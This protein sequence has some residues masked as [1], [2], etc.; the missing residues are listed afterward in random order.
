MFEFA[1]LLADVPKVFFFVDQTGAKLDGL[2]HRAG[3]AFAEPEC[4][5]VIFLGVVNRLQRLRTNAL[6][7]PQMKKLMRSDCVDWIKSPAD[8]LGIDVDSGG[9]SVLHATS[10]WP[11]REMVEEHVSAEGAIVHP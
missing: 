9:V 7:V 5:C 10:S 6:H 4:A 1:D 2:F 3:H 11:A 8:G